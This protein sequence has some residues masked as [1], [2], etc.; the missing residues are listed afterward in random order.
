MDQRKYLVPDPPSRRSR[1]P[2]NPPHQLDE[3]LV[4]GSNIS[5]ETNTTEE[6]LQTSTNSTSSGFPAEVPFESGFPAYHIELQL[7]PV[8]QETARLHS[9]PQAPHTLSR[10]PNISLL[11]DDA[12]PDE[13]SSSVRITEST[14]PQPGHTSLVSFKLNGFMPEIWDRQEDFD[15]GGSRGHFEPTTITKSSKDD[16]FL[17]ELSNA[18]ADTASTLSTTATQHHITPLAPNNICDNKNGPCLRPSNR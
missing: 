4:Y 5:I 13:F 16:I 11:A 12:A 10:E 2:G 14:E 15:F 3:N 18:V 1:N 17:E 7:R 6:Y 9:P 8:A